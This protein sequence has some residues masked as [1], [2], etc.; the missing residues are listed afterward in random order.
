METDERTIVKHRTTVLLSMDLLAEVD[1]LRAV[2]GISR[3]ALLAIAASYFVAKAAPSIRPTRRAE[4]LAAVEEIFR[5]L[6]EK[7]REAPE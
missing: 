5:R 3:S 7:A 2:L 4:S 6:L 1:R